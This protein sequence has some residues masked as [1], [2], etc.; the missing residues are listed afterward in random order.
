[1]F[2][3]H[4]AVK[5]N[6]STQNLKDIYLCSSFNNIISNNIIS[7][8][9][10]YCIP[11]SS[12][13]KNII[14]NNKITDQETVI[15]IVLSFSKNFII[16]NYIQNNNHGLQIESNNNFIYH[17]NMINKTLSNAIDNWSN[18]LDDNYPSDGNYRNDYSAIDENEDEIDDTAYE[19]EGNKNKDNYPLINLVEI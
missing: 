17:N 19:V 11:L 2:S 1:M 5:N 4:K 15:N 3:S 18:V 9:T 7:I 13:N 6:I 8:H 12:S 16:T 14:Y 10:K